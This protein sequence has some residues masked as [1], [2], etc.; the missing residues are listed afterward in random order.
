[1]FTKTTCLGPKVQV[2]TNHKYKMP[3]PTEHRTARPAPEGFTEEVTV[4]QGLDIWVDFTEMSWKSSFRGGEGG[5]SERGHLEKGL[6]TD[7][8]LGHLRQ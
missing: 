7:R 1:M 4:E 5:R 6:G 3:Q 8:R 2:H